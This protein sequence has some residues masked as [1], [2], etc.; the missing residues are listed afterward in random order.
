MAQRRSDSATVALGALRL[1]DLLIEHAKSHAPT[2]LGAS[3]TAWFDL[4]QEADLL[5]VHE[6]QAIALRLEGNK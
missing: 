6:L 2:E 4:M 1:T 5:L 3:S